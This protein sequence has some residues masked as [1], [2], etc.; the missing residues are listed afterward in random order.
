[1]QTKNITIL[2]YNEEEFSRVYHM[3]IH[4]AKVKEGRVMIPNK[5]KEGKVIAAVIDGHVEVLNTLGERFGM[6][7]STGMPDSIQR[8]RCATITLS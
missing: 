2:F 1:M 5:I 3:H 6:E 4:N 8:M 7:A